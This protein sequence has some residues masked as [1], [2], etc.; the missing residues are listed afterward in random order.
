MLYAKKK[1]QQNANLA[2]QRAQIISNVNE[3]KAKNLLRIVDNEVYVYPQ[4]WKDKVTAVNWIKC[5]HVFFMLKHR[6][7]ESDTLNFRDY[8]SGELIGSFKNKKA[9]LLLDFL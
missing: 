3:L 7:K 4:I 8:E 1:V 5:L 6:F 9:S 2:A